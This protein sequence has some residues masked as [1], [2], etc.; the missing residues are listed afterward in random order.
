MLW[1]LI[2]LLFFLLVLGGIALVA[3]AYLGPV[4]AP[5]DFDP[6]QQEI[7]IPVTLELDE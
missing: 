4:F 6:D 7:R 3:Y 2:K 1:R 5:A